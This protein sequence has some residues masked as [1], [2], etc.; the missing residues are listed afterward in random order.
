M[1]HTQHPVEEPHMHGGFTRPLMLVWDH[2]LHT[3]YVDNGGGLGPATGVDR[4]NNVW[5][6]DNAVSR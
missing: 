6:A 3:V 5:I 2:L 1:E 4:G